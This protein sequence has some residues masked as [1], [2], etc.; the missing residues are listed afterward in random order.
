MDAVGIAP[1]QAIEN[2]ALLHE[3]ADAWSLCAAA[4]DGLSD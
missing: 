3:V 2:L 1:L 4:I